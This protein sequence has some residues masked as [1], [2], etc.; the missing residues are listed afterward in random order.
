MMRAVMTFVFAVL[1]E[2]AG[3]TSRY[4][5]AIRRRADQVEYWAARH[6]NKSDGGREL[7]TAAE[8]AGIGSGGC[9]DRPAG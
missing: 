8:R 1:C 6:R 7:G 2:I 4:A 5:D 9:L 3:K